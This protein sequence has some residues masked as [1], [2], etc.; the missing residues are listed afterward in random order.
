MSISLLLNILLVVSTH[1]LLY[2][3]IYFGLLSK[4]SA[5]LCLSFTS[6]PAFHSFFINCSCIRRCR[7]PLVL[8]M[9][10]ILSACKLRILFKEMVNRRLDFLVNNKQYIVC[11]NR[12]YRAENYRFTC[13]ARNTYNISYT[14]SYCVHDSCTPHC[15]TLFVQ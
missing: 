9:S 2:F 6:C 11:T 14:N 4:Q 15:V 10:F 5:M 7:S 13:C 12:I 3:Q 8:V 1:N